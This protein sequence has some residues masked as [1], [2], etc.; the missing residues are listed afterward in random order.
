[1]N[2]SGFRIW[3]S[4]LAAG[5]S[6]NGADNVRIEDCLINNNEYGVNI[7]NSVNCTFR[8]NNVSFNVKNIELQSASNAVIE[9]NI[10]SN[11]GLYDGLESVEG[12]WDCIIRNNTIAN[13]AQSG[14]YFDA[15]TDNMVVYN[16]TIE[17]NKNGVFLDGGSG[18]KVYNNNLVYNTDNQV[19]DTGTSNTWYK[20]YP[21]WTPPKISITKLITMQ[22]TGTSTFSPTA[23]IPTP[24]G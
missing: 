7:Y 21:V 4:Y 14:I 13:N 17:S 11:A 24:P 15:G 18:N 1:V 22:T 2:I 20:T 8:N 12:A 19:I 3:N 5:L 16:N 6:V 10:I 23:S 9:N